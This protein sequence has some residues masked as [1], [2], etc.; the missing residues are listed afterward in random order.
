MTVEEIFTKII[1][2][3]AD[4]VRIHEELANYYDFL[5]LHGYKMCHEYHYLTQSKGYRQLYHFYIKYF[6]KLVNK[7]AE[8]GKEISVIPSAWLGHKKQKVDVRLLRES[9]EIG[10]QLWIDW[11]NST[12]QL[13][14]EMFKQLLNL[15]EIHAA[16]FIKEYL[17]D[18]CEELA[19]AKQKYL[20]LKA[21]NYDATVIIPAQDELCK[22]YKKRIREL[23]FC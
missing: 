4:G 6:E 12:V 5:N 3:A 20:N 21:I 13:Y 18:V 7:D 8:K 15:N 10:M 14:K 22:K 23:N 19:A 11:Q 17:D 9:V 2:H 16:M 1:S